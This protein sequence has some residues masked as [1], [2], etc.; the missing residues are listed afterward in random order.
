M[1]GCVSE[2]RAVTSGIP[3]GSVL[4]PLLFVIYINDLEENITGLISKFADDTKVGG[5]ADSSEDRQRMQQDTDQLE[6]W[7]ERWQMEFK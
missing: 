3:Q 5:I 6:T 7:A 1:E 4:R 2:W